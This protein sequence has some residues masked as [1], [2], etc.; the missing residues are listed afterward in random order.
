TT[1]TVNFENVSEPGGTILIEDNG[2]GMTFEEVRD[3]WMRIATAA[4]RHELVSRKYKRPLTGAKGVGR[5][6]A[7]RLGSKLTLQSTAERNDKTK[8]TVVAE[9][10]WEND[11]TEG[12]DLDKVSVSFTK[13]KMPSD[14]KAGVSLLIAQARDAWTKEEISALKRDLLS[15]QNPFSDLIEKPVEEPTRDKKKRKNN[16]EK[17]PG[18][19]FELYV[20]GS[21]ELDQLS[22]GLA[23]TFLNTAFAKLDGTI[24]EDGCANYKIKILK[25]GQKSALKDEKNSYKGLEGARLRIYVMIY[26]KEFY[27]ETEFGLQAAQTK[28]REEGGVRIYLDEFRVF[29]YGEPGDDWLLLDEYAAKNLDLAKIA[30]P[31][32]Q[33]TKIRDSLQGRPFLLVPKNNQVFGVVVLSQRQH[34]NI[35][36]N[37]TRDRLIETQ[38]VKNLRRFV[39]NGL[40]WAAM[41]WAAF[42]ADQRS[43]KKKD[44]AKS[45]TDLMAE[46]KQTVSELTEIP[47]DKRQLILSHLYQAIDQVAEE[48]QDRISEM[49]MLRILASAGTTIALMN[50]QMRALN[51]VILQTE[52][53]LSDLREEVPKK[54]WKRFHDITTQVSEWR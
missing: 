39:Q 27:E 41:K 5:F 20:D 53:D 37:I 7:R 47:Y 19:N 34:P 44:K 28:G 42:S 49:S 29:P 45:A 8:E 38:A 30:R 2:H 6:A 25:T 51:G 46:A 18:F 36:I 11:F 52:K 26:K 10:D 33:V 12:K 4:K 14:T 31:P 22:G 17:D 35:E 54:L 40:Y 32:E 23:K 21:K 3:S 15:L 9:F 1:V 16:E 24:D 50:H 48:E 13:Q 43:K